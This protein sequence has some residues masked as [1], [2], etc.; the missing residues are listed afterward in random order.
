MKIF[1]HFLYH[2]FWSKI[3]IL[4]LFSVLSGCYLPRNF[5]SRLEVDQLGAWRYIYK[6]TLTSTNLLRKFSEGEWTPEQ[7]KNTKEGQEHVAYYLRDM[8]R[9]EGVQRV[10][11]VEDADFELDFLYI[12]NLHYGKR[13]KFLN[14]ANPIFSMIYEGDTVNIVAGKVNRGYA[15]ELTDRGFVMKG[16]LEVVTD[17]H[18][19][20]HNAHQVDHL[21]NNVKVLSWEM[22]LLTEPA[23]YVS[24]KLDPAKKPNL[25]NNIE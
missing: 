21:A 6:G 15:E 14:K 2:R 18:L 5:E 7:L 23:A 8:R 10:K 12:H 3:G 13:F 4:I 20:Y 16:S 9:I 24:L 22:K 25:Q 17:A 19:S 1:L 11:Y